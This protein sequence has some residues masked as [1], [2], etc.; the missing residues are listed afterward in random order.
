MVVLIGAPMWFD[1]AGYA[2][3]FSNVG[4]ASALR[5]R[6]WSVSSAG[7][8]FAYGRSPDRRLLKQPRALRLRVQAAAVTTLLFRNALTG[9]LT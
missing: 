6:T 7:P 3:P 8:R 5:Q 4:A 2:S 1:S 9:R